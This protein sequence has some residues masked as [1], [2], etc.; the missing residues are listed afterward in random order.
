MVV[1]PFDALWDVGA[2][3][4]DL[5][6]KWGDAD[7]VHFEFPGFKVAAAQPAFTERGGI[8]ALA[9]FLSSFVPGYGQAQLVAFILE[10]IGHPVPAKMNFYLQHPAEFLAV[11]FNK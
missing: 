4:N 5:G 8:Y 10:T 11:L 6:G 1:E 2:W 3:W 9:D 7:P